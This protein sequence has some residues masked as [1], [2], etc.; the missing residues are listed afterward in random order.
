[1]AR[2]PSKSMDAS[3]LHIQNRN[4]TSSSINLINAIAQKKNTLL[5]G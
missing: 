1:C 5:K 3:R 4:N 2:I